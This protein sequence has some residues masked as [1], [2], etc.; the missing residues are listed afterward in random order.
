MNNFIEKNQTFKE[1]QGDKKKRDCFLTSL[2]WDGGEILVHHLCLRTP[3]RILQTK[4][5]MNVFIQTKL[6]S[7]SFSLKK[8][9]NFYWAVTILEMCLIC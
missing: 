6:V 9:K 2:V 8:K 1:E 7:L 4:F 5:E 3:V